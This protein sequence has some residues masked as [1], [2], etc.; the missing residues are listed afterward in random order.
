M[1]PDVDGATM[2]TRRNPASR[3]KKGFCGRFG[4]AQWPQRARDVG[5]R[6]KTTLHQIDYRAADLGSE[7]VNIATDRS[8]LPISQRTL[9]AGG[10]A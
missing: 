2:E 3:T 10:V 7:S 4:M 5:Q 9:V 8:E 6:L 1:F